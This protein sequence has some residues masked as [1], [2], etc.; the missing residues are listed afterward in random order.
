MIG[1]AA[2]AC[3]EGDARCVAVRVARAA[4]EGEPVAL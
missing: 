2:T 3:V 1:N 4:P